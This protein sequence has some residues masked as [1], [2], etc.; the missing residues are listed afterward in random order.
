MILALVVQGKSEIRVAPPF[1][2]KQEGI[3]PPLGGAAAS[4]SL[5]P[6]PPLPEGEAAARRAGDPAASA[7]ARLCGVATLPLSGRSRERAL[8]PEI[9]LRRDKTISWL[10]MGPACKSGY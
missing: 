9:T 1:D 8:G 6:F 3:C 4:P 7:P 10:N 5:L 2:M